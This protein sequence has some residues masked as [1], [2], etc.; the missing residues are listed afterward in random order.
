MG[1]NFVDR[2][3]RRNGKEKR[4]EMKCETGEN[5]WNLYDD[6]NRYRKRVPK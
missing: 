4:T 1:K 3:K 6:L 2:K 5:N